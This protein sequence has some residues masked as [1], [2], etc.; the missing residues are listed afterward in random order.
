MLS[1]KAA[2]SSYGG[3]RQNAQLDS[4]IITFSTAARDSWS[5]WK[6]SPAFARFSCSAFHIVSIRSFCAASVCKKTADVLLEVMQ[7]KQR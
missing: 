6:S 3:C 7:R 4:S 1:H 5:V 2:N